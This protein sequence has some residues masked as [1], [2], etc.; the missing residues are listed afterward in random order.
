[1]EKGQRATEIAA[2]YTKAIA[3]KSYRALM[4]RLLKRQA[5]QSRSN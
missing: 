4:S 5:I 1:L 3:L 2:S